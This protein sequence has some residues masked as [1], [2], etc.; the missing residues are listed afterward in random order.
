MPAISFSGVLI[1][2]LVAVAVPVALALVPRLPVPGAVL[3]VVAG[4]LVGPSVLGWVHVDASIQ[5]LSDLGLGMLLFLAGLE[6]DVH[7]LRGPLGRLAGWAFAGSVLLGLA[8]GGVL[9]LAGVGANPVFLA[10]VLVSTSA[11][12]L[13]PLLKD[14]GQHRTRF[15]QLVMA[16]GAL[17]EVVPVMML[18]LLFS[19]TSKTSASRLAS[20]AIFLALLAVIGLAL[21]RVRNL[22]A[23]D[24]MLDRLEDRSAQLRVRA[25]LT[26][27]L[28]FAVLADRFGFAS[29]LGA[30]AAGLLV[31]TIDLTG[32]APH[33]QF[34]TKL[35]GIGFG[36]LVPV[37]FITT[38]VQF[39]ARALAGNVTALAEVPLFLL[40]LLVVRAVPALAYVRLIGR[41]RAGAA[42]LM[43]ATT[44]T[45]VIVATQIG[46]ASGQV[47]RTTGA[48]LLAAGL[49][50]AA[51]F[52]AVS[53]WLLP[54]PLQLDVQ[55][56]IGNTGRYVIHR[57][58]D[59][60]PAAVRAGSRIRAA[61]ARG[62][63]DRLRAAQQ[64]AVPGAEALRGGRRGDQD[65][66]A[67]AGP[68]APPGVHAYRG[69]PRT[70]P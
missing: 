60:A 62:A 30:F 29:I 27:A 49:L 35:E 13:L 47:S 8:C 55:S 41:R 36:F 31:R 54:A 25:A 63:D 52:P 16:A 3:E 39:D 11:G 40:A 48:A 6:I 17:A 12:L 46:V 70:A 59:P 18:S 53:A 50:S 34:Q 14:A 69:G 57:D 15:G 56:D 26:L 19:A 51:I 20:L 22:A 64:L 66:R 24:R 9:S 2:A 58:P 45:F 10:V 44:L 23:L 32:R 68:P 42:G 21:G 67:A 38:G 7:H 61:Q 37:F 33:P 4:I 5:V 43:Q 28:A 1:I 65:R